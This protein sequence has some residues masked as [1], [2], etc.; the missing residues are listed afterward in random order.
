MKKLNL[1]VLLYVILSLIS[2]KDN[3][4]TIYSKDKKKCITV[5][6]NIQTNTRCYY[7]GKKSFFHPTTE[8]VKV[9]LDNIDLL[10][11][12]IVGYW[13][14]NGGW[15]LYNNNSIILEN[16]LDTIKYKFYNKLPT[17]EFGIHT[18]KPILDKKESFRINLTYNEIMESYD[19]LIEKNLW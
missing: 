9:S 17:G 3:N 13:S 19:V 6:T 11:E 15:V 12:E 5:I 18:L 10:A 7:V 16:K 14:E 8:Y 2:C 1:I 4:F